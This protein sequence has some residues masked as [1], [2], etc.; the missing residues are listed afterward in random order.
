MQGG[1]EFYLNL[2]YKQ[3][4]TSLFCSGKSRT[5]CLM[6]IESP[7]CPNT[8]TN[9]KSFMWGTRYTKESHPGIITGVN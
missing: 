3:S 9:K 1:S 6:Q 4:D 7:R 2:N 8:I 5:D